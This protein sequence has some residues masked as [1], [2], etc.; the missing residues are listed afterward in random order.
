[1]FFNLKKIL[2]ASFLL[3]IPKISIAQIV[4]VEDRRVRL[5]DSAT[6]TGFVDLGLNIYKNDKN[7][8]TAR[9]SSQLESARGKHL[10][11]LLLGYNFVKGEGQNF[12]NDGFTHFR[13]NYE[14]NHI[15]TWEA[16]TQAQYNERTKVRFRG[17]VGTGGRVKIKLSDVQRF[18]IGVA[19]MFERNVFND[20]TTEQ[21][22]FRMSS[23][24]SYNVKIGGNAKI[25]HTT[26][27]QPVFENWNNNRVSSEVSFLMG[28]TKKL[29]FKVT[30]NIS[31]DN[32]PRLPETIPDLVYSWTNGL[33]WDF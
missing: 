33:R 17:L 12:L 19:C 9:A 18:Y 32:D 28:I 25:V 2:S 21:N 29:V 13:H 1:M 22:D 30:A 6:T 16:F 11:L 20:V 26:Y 7:L 27:F 23:Y 5:K 14:I 24:L 31:Y 15:F 8:T 3:F 4:N 10:F